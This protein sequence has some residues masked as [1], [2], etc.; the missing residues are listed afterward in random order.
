MPSPSSE[1]IRLLLTF[2]PA[3]TAPTFA[4]VMVLVCG[5]ILAPGRRTVAAS[6]RVMGLSD[7]G[8]FSKYHRVL[9]QAQWSPLP[10]S[11]LLLELIIAS[12]LV[13]GQPLL[14][15]IDDT[16][17]RRKG[18]KLRL[19]GW[20]RDP[21][22]KTDSKVSAI[23]W[24]CL[25][26]LVPVPWSKRH[27]ALPF[28]TVPAP[29]EKVC[30]KLGRR[31]KTP[32]ELAS[33]MIR[34]VRSWQ[35]RQDIV[36]LADGG[37]AAVNLVHDCQE[38]G[39][40]LIS[41][42]RLDASLYHFLEPRPAGRRGPRP[43]KGER[44]LSPKQRLNDPATV[45]TELEV[46]WYR[47]KKKHLEVATGISLWHRTG[48]TPVALR[49][50][51]VRCPKGSFPPCA[52]SASVDMS[53]AALLSTYVLRWN[54]EVAFEEVRAQL[55]FETQRGWADKT[56]ERS[57]PCLFGIFSLVVL[58][59]QRLHPAQLPIQRSVWYDKDEASFSDALAAV[60]MH[61]WTQ[62]QRMPF[63]YQKYRDSMSD[64]HMRLI[65]QPIW[66]TLLQA[67]CYST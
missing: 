62:A 5:S 28:M 26:I 45:W 54:L 61:L 18:K 23:R 14:L 3:F 8:N 30:K 43:K 40:T 15:V 38:L 42:L 46:L 66:N 22:S 2:A 11:R 7:E 55:G 56:I 53:P 52:Y 59:A 4:K 47:G 32:V 60:R 34:L 27:W 57:T 24:G 31:H 51:L 64:P 17:E 67:V 6:L 9:S 10:L 12:L 49:W 33:F 25:A 19:K 41:R 16:L 20:F 36:L 65:P 44:D 63:G 35:P 50:V 1:I 58:L 21:L 48:S 13:P 29:S 37:Y 39:V